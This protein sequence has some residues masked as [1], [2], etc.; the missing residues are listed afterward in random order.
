M[1]PQR[2]HTKIHMIYNQKLGTNHQLWIMVGY[3]TTN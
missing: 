3:Q 2:R 1:I